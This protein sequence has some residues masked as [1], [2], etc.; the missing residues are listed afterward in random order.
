MAAANQM[1]TLP[2]PPPSPRA[3]SPRPSS[4][5]HITSSS[6][7]PSLSSSTSS[8]VHTSLTASGSDASGNHGKPRSFRD[9]ALLTQFVQATKQQQEQATG[10]S[11]SSNINN[12][13]SSG[14]HEAAAGE[15]ALIH[16]R[17]G[18]SRADVTGAENDG[19]AQEMVFVHE[20]DEEYELRRTGG[21]GLGGHSPPELDEQRPVT[22]NGKDY[23]QYPEGPDYLTH[24]HHNHQPQQN[25]NHQQPQRQHQQHRLIS[26]SR[27]PEQIR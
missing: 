9:M 20:E 7:A 25:V 5:L 10:R 11:S 1:K 17:S 2:P 4:S 3:T 15:H 18:S 8:P 16:G 19:D 27:S 13:N 26:P 6:S 12:S 23:M 21:D 14:S 22:E 24:H